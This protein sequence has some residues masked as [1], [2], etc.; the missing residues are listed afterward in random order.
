M[1]NKVYFENGICMRKFFIGNNLTDK[2]TIEAF[3]D[4][5]PNGIVK[6]LEAIDKLE[7]PFLTQQM[8]EDLSDEERD[9]VTKHNRGKCAIYNNFFEFCELVLSGKKF[10]QQFLYDIYKMHF[11]SDSL[12]EL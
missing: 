6:L 9:I 4:D 1:F 2:V 10:S 7:K 3:W 5:I 12:K 8:F 11:T